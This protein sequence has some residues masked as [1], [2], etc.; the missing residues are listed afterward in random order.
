MGEAITLNGLQNLLAERYLVLVNR[1]VRCEMVDG[2][3]GT[4]DAATQP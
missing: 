3:S 1:V 2:G 4:I